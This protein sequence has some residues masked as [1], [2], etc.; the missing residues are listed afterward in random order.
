MSVWKENPMWSLLAAWGCLLKSS[1]L[2]SPSSLL[3]PRLRHEEQHSGGRNESLQDTLAHLG[4]CRKAGT[5]N[6]GD[7]RSRLSPRGFHIPPRGAAPVAWEPMRPAAR[8]SASA[9][10]AEGFS[11]NLSKLCHR[12]RSRT[13]QTLFHLTVLKLPCKCASNFY[14]TKK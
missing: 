9:L 4:W 1:H 8:G 14:L 10:G 3:H 6:A 7:S 2:L 5:T 11:G 12:E 13:S